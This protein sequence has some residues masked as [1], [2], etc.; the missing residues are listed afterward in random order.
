MIDDG[1]ATFSTELDEGVRN[2]GISV[3]KS[4]VRTP[5]ANAFCERL[6]GTVRREWLDYVIAINERHLRQILRAWVSHY[7][8]GRPP[9][10]LGPGIPRQLRACPSHRAHRHRLAIGEAVTL[11]P[12]L[13]RLH[14]ENKPDHS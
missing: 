3:L 11:I 4:P 9:S 14:H 7:N 8:R 2:L 12:V 5:T 1:Q 13:L 10:S 6:I